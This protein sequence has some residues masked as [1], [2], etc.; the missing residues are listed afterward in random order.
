VSIDLR[1][2]RRST[3]NRL[4]CWLVWWFYESHGAHPK[5]VYRVYS[6][7]EYFTF[8]SHHVWVDDLRFWHTLYRAVGMI[9][10]ACKGV[11][12]RGERKIWKKLDG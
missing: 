8:S 10:P 11:W 4:I 6:H 9:F 5:R 7:R 12:D 3:E 1:S 2:K